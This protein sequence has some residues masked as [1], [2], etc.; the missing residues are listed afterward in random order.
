MLNEVGETP[1]WFAGRRRTDGPQ[2]MCELRCVVENW[3]TL[4]RRLT[5]VFGKARP[6]IDDVARWLQKRMAPEGKRLT[7]EL[8]GPLRH[9]A[10]GPE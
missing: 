1:D 6:L 4:D 3:K 10:K 8:T 2:A 7:F 9:V 5:P